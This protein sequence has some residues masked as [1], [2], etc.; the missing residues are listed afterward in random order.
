MVNTGDDRLMRALEILGDP[1]KFAKNLQTLKDEQT[2]LDEIISLAGKAS[3]I[4]QKHDLL[5]SEI[6]ARQAE[7]ENIREVGVRL[8]DKATADAESITDKAT[9]KAADLIESAQQKLDDAAAR[10]QKAQEALAE[11]ERVTGELAAREGR[12]SKRE[13]ELDAQQAKLDEIETQLLQEKSRLASVSDT[14]KQAV[15]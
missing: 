10:Q 14:L 6:E 4:T 13:G 5:D 11:T 9:L 3:E 2:K 8:R 15:G 12:I 1:V 7:V